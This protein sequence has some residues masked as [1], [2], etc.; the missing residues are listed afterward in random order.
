MAGKETRK[1]KPRIRRKTIKSKT[2]IIHS[3]RL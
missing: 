2:R 3:S 1:E